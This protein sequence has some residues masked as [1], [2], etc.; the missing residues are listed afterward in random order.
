MNLVCVCEPPTLIN[1]S[2]IVNYQ[3]D[4]YYV[5]NTRTRLINTSDLLFVSKAIPDLIDRL[6]SISRVTDKGIPPW[7]F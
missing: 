5:I 2:Y 6:I 7:T 4:V 1:I 3:L